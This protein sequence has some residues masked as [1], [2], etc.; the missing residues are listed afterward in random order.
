MWISS[1]EEQK[2]WNEINLKVS[3]ILNRDVTYEP[4][5]KVF[6]E[7]VR[8]LEDQQHELE[9]WREEFMGI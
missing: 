3:K 9:D 2:E 6:L 8:K 5:S 1:K 4:I 7:I